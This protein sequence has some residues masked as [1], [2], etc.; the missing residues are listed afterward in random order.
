M[1]RGSRPVVR[2]GSGAGYSGDRID[3]AAALAASGRIDYLCFE[4]LAERTIAIAHGRRQR[5]PDQGFDLLL[6]DRL[7]AVLP[8][9]RA[10]GVKIISNMG[11]ANP[12]AAARTAVKVSRDLGL[13]GIRVA[14]VLGDDVLSHVADHPQAPLDGGGSVADL[15]DRLIAAN[16]YLGADGIVEALAGGADIVLTGRVGDPALF[17]APLV[18]EFGWRPDDWTRLGRGTI[19]G[20]LL[21]CAGQLTG[22]YFADPGRI[23]VPGLADLGFPLAEVSPDGSAILTKLEGS[24]GRI[25]TATCKQQ[26]LYEI[27]DPAAYL[28]ADVVADIRSVRFS[29]VAENRIAFSGGDGAARPDSLKVSLGYSDGFIGEG[30]ISYAGPNALARG[31]LALDILRTRLTRFIS[32]QDLRF[33]VIGVDSVNRTN[34]TVP[35]PVEVRIR[36]VG[37]APNGPTAQRI[38]SEVEAL[39]TNGPAGGGGAAGSV[40]EVVAVASTLIDRQ[41][42]TPSV[43]FEEVS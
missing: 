3:P 27:Q 37:R 14:A 34:A 2:L 32:P 13:R 21:E 1:N 26:L 5:D 11:A 9:C 19:I 24:G 15:K 36:V 4:C 28:Q 10:N 8:A 43:H 16:A 33:D 22:G 42:V 29:E 41:L 17:L 40:R 39:Y 6:E 35:E 31:R 38:V 25:T 18:H 7:R 20:H 23:D 30:Q 12:L